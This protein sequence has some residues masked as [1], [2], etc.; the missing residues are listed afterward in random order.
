VFTQAPPQAVVPPPHTS[1]QTPLTHDCPAAHFMPHMP[2]LLTSV[3]VLTHEPAQLVCPVV[4]VVVQA[5]AEQTCPAA[6]FMP[7]MPQ[8]AASVWRLAHVP[9][10]SV[11]PMATHIDTHEPSAH[12]RPVPHVDPLVLLVHFQPLAIVQVLHAPL[13]ASAQHL[14]PTHAPDS[15]SSPSPQVEP[16][17][18]FTHSP[19]KHTRPLPHGSAFG[20]L[21]HIQF[22]AAVHVLHT[23]VQAAPQHFPL[24]QALDWQSSFD[25]QSPPGLL[26]AGGMQRLVMH[27]SPVPHGAAWASQLPVRLQL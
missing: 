26:A 4:H 19:A 7:H 17:G 24:T 13:H 2:Q 18:F 27:T 8:L 6:H 5:P 22:E 20:W 21:T 12:A 11:R 23:P 3:C 9:S 16:A 15:H 10:Q 14:P 1:V 25:R